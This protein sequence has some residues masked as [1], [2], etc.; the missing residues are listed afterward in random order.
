MGHILPCIVKEIS[1]MKRM[2]Y[3]E[4]EI[5]II[6]FETEDV[7]TDSAQIAEHV[8]FQEYYD[9]IVNIPINQ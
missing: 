6:E 7:I 8:E 2:E 1:I 3:I 9:N 5:E 4:P